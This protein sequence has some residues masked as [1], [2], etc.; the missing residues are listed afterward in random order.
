MKIEFKL[1]EFNYSKK[2]SYLIKATHQL[3][4]FLNEKLK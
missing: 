4:I 1:V 3:Y 2:Y